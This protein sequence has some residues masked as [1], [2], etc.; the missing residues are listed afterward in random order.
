MRDACGA[1]HPTHPSARTASHHRHRVWLVSVPS[2]S[3]C[4]HVR[5]GGLGPPG[6]A[7]GSL[8]RS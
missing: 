6:G 4:T 1:K 7:G 5:T 3:S 2:N 8:A